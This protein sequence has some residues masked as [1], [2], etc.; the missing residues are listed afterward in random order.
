M[1]HLHWPLVRVSGSHVY[2]LIS[3]IAEA[4]K[5]RR[6]VL[7]QQFGSPYALL[8]KPRGS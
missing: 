6:Q 4:A 1:R 2:V 5:V 3:P 7:F 8:C